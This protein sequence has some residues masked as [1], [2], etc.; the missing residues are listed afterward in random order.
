MRENRRETWK[1]MVRVFAKS[2]K[3][4]IIK[5]I[6]NTFLRLKENTGI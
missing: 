3:K 6:T 4:C 1:K 5:K 2:V